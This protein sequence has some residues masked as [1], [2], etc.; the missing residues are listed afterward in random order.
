MKKIVAVV[1]LLMVGACKGPA[2]SDGKN[3][4]GIP[5]VPGQNG[6]PANISNYSGYINSDV[7]TVSV[8]VLG[9]NSDLSVFVQ[10]A[11][12]TFTEL[13][14]YYPALG[15]NVYYLASLGQVVIYNGLKGGVTQYKV[16]VENGGVNAARFK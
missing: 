10:D 3:G 5:G 13:P 9:V 7:Q 11:S 8:P 14:I 6:A 16:T 12:N 1:V 15:Y 4:V 2:G